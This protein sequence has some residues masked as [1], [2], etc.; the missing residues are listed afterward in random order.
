MRKDK[1]VN[2]AEKVLKEHKAENVVTID[3]SEKTPF[4]NYYVLA[5]AANARHLGAL[6]EIVEEELEKN[7]IAINHIEGKSQSG[8]ILIDA[9]HVIINIFSQEERDRINITELLNRK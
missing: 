5:T 3:V 4:A 2:L 7:K 9:Y 1:V 6:K 8:W